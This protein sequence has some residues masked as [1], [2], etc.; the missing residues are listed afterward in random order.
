ML[1]SL[2]YNSINGFLIKNLDTREKVNV[3]RV[4]DGDTVVVNGISVRLLGI[5][6]PERGEKYYS[7]AK[8]FLGGIVMNKT[9][10]I[11][12]YGKDKYNRDLGYLFSSSGENIN[13]EIV[14]R[15]YANYYF[16]SG[17]DYYYDEFVDSWTE[18]IN[19]GENLCEMSD[20]AECIVLKEFKEERVILE[21]NCNIVNL[22]GWSMKDE[23]RKKFVFGRVS[24]DYKDIIIVTNEDFD[25]DYVWTST[26]DTLFLRDDEG[27]LVLWE[28]Y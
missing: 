19:S 14:R 27:K 8:T 3:E 13:S 15:G 4:I 9:I 6:T 20:Y 10:Y 12:R 22:E 23:G 5:N 17:K 11:E 1:V 21:N 18:C 24:L 25:E 26:G 2:N 28:S 16:P 7:E